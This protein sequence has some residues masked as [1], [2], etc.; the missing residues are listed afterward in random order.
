MKE[1][2]KTLW[3]IGHS[4][5]SFEEFVAILHLFNID[6]I[7]DVRSFPSLHK[8]PQ[9]NED[10]LEISLPQNNSKQSHLTMLF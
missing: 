4:T 10:A 5:R 9:F 3:P 1:E 8:F 2:N 7:A 6:L